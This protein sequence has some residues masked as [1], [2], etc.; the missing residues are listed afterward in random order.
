MWTKN[1]GIFGCNFFMAIMTGVVLFGLSG[2]TV[3][4]NG[5]APQLDQSGT[6]ISGI[7]PHGTIQSEQAHVLMGD[8]MRALWKEKADSLGMMHSKIESENK[9]VKAEDRKKK[10]PVDGVTKSAECP[11]EVEFADGNFERAVRAT[12]GKPDGCIYPADLSGCEVL[13]ASGYEITSLVDIANLPALKVLNVYNNM[14]SDLSPLEGKTGIEYLNLGRN[15]V[16]DV[17]PL[18]TLTGLVFLELGRGNPFTQDIDV[19]TLFDTVENTNSI[20]DITP[21]ANLAQLEVLGLSDNQINL[22]QVFSSVSNGDALRLL[23][24]LRL[25][26]LDHNPLQDFGPVTELGNL[27]G[28]GLGGTNLTDSVLQGKNDG[29]RPIFSYW[30]FLYGVLLSDSPDIQSLF[31][32][33]SCGGLAGLSCLNATNLNDVTALS[34]LPM[35]QIVQITNSKVS[36]VEP[37]MGKPQLGFLDLSGNS[38][39]TLRPWVPFRV[40]TDI[41]NWMDDCDL[42]E[43]M[44]SLAYVWLTGNPLVTDASDSP[45]LQIA[46]LTQCCDNVVYYDSSPSNSYELCMSFTG[47]GMVWPTYNCAPYQAGTQ[48]R[49]LAWPATGY[50]FDH[51]TVDGVVMG[52][53]GVPH[54][55]V[56]LNS[57]M[58]VQAVFEQISSGGI[59]F[60]DPVVEALVRDS[61]DQPTGDIVI[62]PDAPL[63]QLSLTAAV[64]MSLEGLQHFSGLKELHIK[65]TSDQELQLDILPL[66]WL[67]DLEELSIENIPL[68]ERRLTA[69]KTLPKLRSLTLK[70]CG[71]TSVPPVHEYGVHAGGNEDA[72]DAQLEYLDLSHNQIRK[73]AGLRSLVG[74]RYLDI[75]HNNAVD[76]AFLQALTN[77]EY[78]DLSHNN[79]VD[80]A[81]LQALTNLE[82]LDLSYNQSWLSKEGDTSVIRDGLMDLAPLVA[83][84]EAQ[85]QAAGALHRLEKVDIRGNSYLRV[86]EVVKSAFNPADPVWNVPAILKNNPVMQV[87]ALEDMGVLVKNWVPDFAPSVPSEEY[88]NNRVHP[89]LMT[90]FDGGEQA[91]PDATY[92]IQERVLAQYD[93]VMGLKGCMFKADNVSDGGRCRLDSNYL[94]SKHEDIL[95]QCYT[96]AYRSGRFGLLWNPGAQPDPIPYAVNANPKDPDDLF[97]TENDHIDYLYNPAI[98]TF[99]LLFSHFVENEA[100]S[101][102][103]EG[104]TV[105]TGAHTDNTFDGIVGPNDMNADGRV[106]RTDVD[107]YTRG[108]M[109]AFATLRADHPEIVQD[110][111]G[112]GSW[113]SRWPWLEYVNGIIHEGALAT[114]YGPDVVGAS[115][116]GRAELEQEAWQRMWQSYQV[117]ITAPEPDWWTV[118]NGALPETDPLR[119][120]HFPRYHVIPLSPDCFVA[121]ER[122]VQ[123]LR[124]YVQQLTDSDLRRMRLGFCTALLDDGGFF[125]YGFFAGSLPPHWYEEFSFD[126]G[127]PLPEYA[128]PGGHY[129]R[130]RCPNGN[131]YFYVRE[132]EAGIVIVNPGQSPLDLMT[133]SKGAELGAGD[134]A[135]WLPEGRYRDVTPY[136]AYDAHTVD[137]P[138]DEV[139]DLY[140]KYCAGE[141]FKIPAMDG[142]ILARSAVADPATEYECNEPLE[143]IGA[144][145]SG[146]VGVSLFHYQLP[147]NAPEG[148]ILPPDRFCAPIYVTGGTVSQMS[149]RIDMEYALD[150]A[151][152]ATLVSP[153]G[154]RVLLISNV[155]A[156]GQDFLGTVLDD[157]AKVPIWSWNDIEDVANGIYP[158]VAPYT[159]IYQPAIPLARFRGEEMSGNW[160]LELVFSGSSRNPVDVSDGYGGGQGIL[161]GVSL[162]F[163]PNASCQ[164][165]ALPLPQLSADKQ[166]TRELTLSVQTDPVDPSATP[167]SLYPAAGVHSLP[168]NTQVNVVATPA[169]GYVFDRWLEEP[170]TTSNGITVTLDAS[171][172]RTAVFKQAAGKVTLVVTPPGCG[173]LSKQNGDKEEPVY[174]GVYRLADTG[175]SVTF[176][177]TPALGTAFKEWNVSGGQVKTNLVES[178]KAKL[179]IVPGVDTHVTAVFDHAY[180]LDLS[181]SEG[182]TASLSIDGKSI[183]N[184]IGERIVS[185]MQLCAIDG[186]PDVGWVYQYLHGELAGGVILDLAVKDIMARNGGSSS[187]P[188]LMWEGMSASTI[189]YPVLAYKSNLDDE[190]HACVVAEG[191]V[192]TQCSEGQSCW[193]SDAESWQRMLPELHKE[194]L[195]E[196]YDVKHVHLTAVLKDDTYRFSQ[197]KVGGMGTDPLVAIEESGYTPIEQEGDHLTLEVN[198]PMRVEAEF[199]PR[200][201]HDNIDIKY[202]TEGAGSVKCYQITEGE[203]EDYLEPSGGCE[204][205]DEFSTECAIQRDRFD[206]LNIHC[207]PDNEGGWGFHSMF[208]NG[209][210]TDTPSGLGPRQKSCDIT[211]NPT[212]LQIIFGPKF[213][214]VRDGDGDV[215]VNGNRWTF[216]NDSIVFRGPHR[217]CE[218]NECVTYVD[219]V[220]V[221]ALPEPGSAFSHWEVNGVVIAGGTPYLHILMDEPKKVKVVFKTVHFLETA[222]Y[223]YD[224]GIVSPPPGKT[225]HAV[226]SQVALAATNNAGYRFCSWDACV[227]NRLSPVTSIVLNPSG[228]NTLTKVNAYFVPTYFTR[229]EVVISTE[230][231]GAVTASPSPDPDGLYAEGTLVEVTASNDPPGYMFSHYEV[232]KTLNDEYGSLRETIHETAFDRTLDYV[233]SFHEAEIE[234]VFIPSTCV[235]NLSIEGEPDPGVDFGT[236]F[237]DPDKS[238]YDTFESVEISAVPNCGYEFD[239]WTGVDVPPGKE[240]DRFLNVIANKDQMDFTAV[241][242]PRTESVIFTQETE[243]LG[244]I[245]VDCGGPSCETLLPSTSVTAVAC[246]APGWSFVHFRLFLEDGVFY[247]PYPAEYLTA[248]RTLSGVI[249]EDTH[250]VA[251]F[252]FQLVTEAAGE[253]GEVTPDPATVH[254][255]PA[256]AKVEVT[257]EPHTGYRFDHWRV[258]GKAISPHSPA[259]K[260]QNGRYILEVEMSTN[261]HVVAVFGPQPPSTP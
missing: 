197:W 30:P 12:I 46:A 203:G 94:K 62:D 26:L 169:Q 210:P 40:A 59:C 223:P 258:D 199:I 240:H 24:G 42:Q 134:R 60:G 154:T 141:Y 147:V 18:S 16:E 159:G 1:D 119:R 25:L 7:S 92:P 219:S 246:P 153:S 172:S 76:T 137:R 74:L 211:V 116:L 19:A 235:I 215:F 100:L 28:L 255:Y 220:S 156:L 22:T 216:T 140:G 89:C 231:R 186:T 239:H 93:F 128:A 101:P 13:D 32:L 57:N 86:G 232:T 54:I 179:E 47:E 243:G 104:T 195:H 97:L 202:V 214:L 34:V 204:E 21:L 213:E 249:C 150:C 229:G 9:A 106:D 163:G 256:G 39:T 238:S 131:D 48:V 73:A 182:G 125:N 82:Y 38:I 75:S 190:E 209:E 260:S 118:W 162:G 180:S 188:F 194:P 115:V 164:L 10:S 192:S 221:C 148:H 98:S 165:A 53:T 198:E 176:Y 49:C 113:P 56:T 79:A 23:T 183:S 33:E 151:V 166:G 191:T 245:N 90:G 230:H 112:V 50:R 110:A 70:N 218:N 261:R 248:E 122:E 55:G 251:V 160:Q 87:K 36:T 108:T 88:S 149:V 8:R 130:V 67:A 132:Y 145:E 142:R 27:V 241:F 227:A 212:E 139:D 207:D 252:G 253:N 144:L 6:S 109:Q 234:A 171:K 68:D 174:P 124:E 187:Y 136:T 123:V 45:Q 126:V 17:G 257:A 133:G 114:G 178:G 196:G 242:V 61:I 217:V 58:S 193:P 111:N 259:I 236:V 15:L 35:L 205:I 158:A 181:S 4:Q 247:D 244:T 185:G 168:S 105:F 152:R 83:L 222:V 233:V 129:R 66:G 201:G 69:L 135:W 200:S 71:L 161:H 175:T 99:P 3:A 43:C 143:P 78:L 250:L 81:F 177:A 41:T 96:M 167:G 170:G 77:L 11:G 127:V 80:T 208:I 44:L 254:P 146:Y 206:E 224:G 20:E 157:N 228:Q 107:L 29:N 189:F 63:Q 91:E 5:R 52:S 51:W 155:G 85:V 117:T 121:G 184:P 95:L 225:P 14:I 65:A 84:A 72:G 103:R 2:L 37:L 237:R 173:G 31:G 120:T 226:G 64:I 102:M 138:V